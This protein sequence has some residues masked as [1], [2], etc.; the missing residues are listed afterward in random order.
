MMLYVMCVAEHRNPG[1]Y[2]NG[3]AVY[4]PIQSK[5]YHQMEKQQKSYALKNSVTFINP[6]QFSGLYFG[7]RTELFKA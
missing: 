3:A 2:G 5:E 7:V 1:H 6:L 4:L